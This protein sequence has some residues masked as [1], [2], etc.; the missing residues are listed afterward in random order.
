MILSF[1]TDNEMNYF[2]HVKV[3]FQK[4]YLIFEYI[5]R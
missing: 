1:D 3:Y 4:M 5:V 2:N